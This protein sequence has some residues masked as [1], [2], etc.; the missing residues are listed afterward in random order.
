MKRYSII[1]IIILALLAL[2]TT[3][4]VALPG[5]PNFSPQV[6]GDGDVWGTKGTAIIKGPNGHNNQSFNMLFIVVYDDG[7]LA[8][9][10]KPVADA[11]PGNPEYTPRWWT[12]TAE[13]NVA[14]HA[15]FTFYEEK[16]AYDLGGT[17]WQN[18]AAHVALGHLTITEGPPAVEGAPPAYFV[19]PLLPVK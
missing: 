17:D 13:W 11:A 7:E 16:D 12:H 14:P 18:L 5:K 10:Q 6:Y 19:C 3:P 1:G 2:V 4:V 15:T 8:P 9:V